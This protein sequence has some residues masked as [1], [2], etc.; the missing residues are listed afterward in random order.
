MDETR[1][2]EIDPAEA[3][4]VS[5]CGQPQQR[6]TPARAAIFIAYDQMQV[7]RFV[8][9]RDPA[10]AATHRARI[11]VEALR[12]IVIH[13]HSR[14]VYKTP[15]RAPYRRR[16]RHVVVDLRARS[17][18]AGIEA[19]GMAADRAYAIAHVRAL[20]EVDV[21]RGSHAQMMIADRAAWELPAA[22]IRLGGIERHAMLVHPVTAADPSN[23]RQ[24]REVAFDTLEP[25]RTRRGVVVGDRDN[26]ARDGIET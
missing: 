15:A 19:N 12:R 22:D 20:E 16:E 7:I 25:R 6:H 8:F 17:A 10:S 5:H 26:V 24:V 21:A 18:Q 2:G 4:A 23:I 1:T 14:I 3:R 9:Y 13:F 11:F